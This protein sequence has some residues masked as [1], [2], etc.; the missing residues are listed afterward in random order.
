MKKVIMILIIL[1]GNSVTQAEGYRKN[2]L[3]SI[4]FKS[5]N[6]CERDANELV[7]IMQYFSNDGRSLVVSNSC[8]YDYSRRDGYNS[9]LDS[10]IKTNLKR[11]LHSLGSFCMTEIYV[12]P[13]RRLLALL[14]N[15][16]ATIFIVD[17]SAKFGCVDNK[18]THITVKINL[19]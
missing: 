11:G 12:E 6:S 10:A 13:Y 17:N 15:E 3:N 19:R 9:R 7:E 8:E 16:E 2:E 14:S 5:S 4:W 18:Q 1:L